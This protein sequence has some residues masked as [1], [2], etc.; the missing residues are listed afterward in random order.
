MNRKHYR[1]IHHANVNQCCINNKCWCECKRHHLCE[2]NYIWNPA[3]CSCENWQYL[4]SIM[5]DSVITS[6]VIIEETFPTNFNE[7]KAIVKCKI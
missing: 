2:K 7:K 1:S 4:E 6:D 3:T 5:D